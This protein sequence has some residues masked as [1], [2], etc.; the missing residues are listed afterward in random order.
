VV[1]VAPRQTGTTAL[2]R[3]RPVFEDRRVSTTACRIPAGAG[4]LV[5]GR[6]Y[7]WRVGVSDTGAAVDSAHT[8]SQASSFVYKPGANQA[9]THTSFTFP[10]AGRSVTGYASLVVTSD[11]PDAE[12]CMLEYSLGS[13]SARGEWQA[14]GAFPKAQGSFVGMWASDSAVIRAGMTFPSPCVVRATVLGRQ[15]QSG[16]ALLPLVIN[17]PPPPTRRGCGCD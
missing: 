6:T 17:P 15:G 10:K 4:G 9:E 13:D 14:V 8:Q 5:T 7:A 11:V 16:E 12:L 1:E 2:R 3:N